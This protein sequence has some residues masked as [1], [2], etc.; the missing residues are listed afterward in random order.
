ML[1]DKALGRL[2]ISSIDGD[3]DG[4]GDIDQIV[5]YG[6]RSFSIYKSDGT[7]VFDSGD[8]FEQITAQVIPEL[9][10]GQ[11]NDPDEFDG[12][13]DNKGPAPEGVTIGRFGEKVLAFVGLERVGGVMI[14]DVT[15]PEAASFV[16]YAPNLPEDI[17][18][19]GILYIDQNDSPTGN[20]LLVTTNEISGTTAV[21]QVVPEPGTIIGLIAAVAATGT[22]LKRKPNDA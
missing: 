5:A 3:I 13:S 19:E 18:P 21:Y 22:A 9:F 10:N 14:Y 7:Q 12:R 11:D 15:N 2:N 17:S 16:S 4:D 8:D 6:G 20:P 1:E